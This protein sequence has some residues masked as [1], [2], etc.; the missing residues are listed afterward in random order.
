MAR[1]DSTDQSRDFRGKRVRGGEITTRGFAH[2]LGLDDAPPPHR[3]KL[4][5]WLE[6]HF[7][8][9]IGEERA[10]ML[11]ILVSP[12]NPSGP[13]F[14]EGEHI[15]VSYK[16]ESLSEAL[17]SLIKADAPGRVAE[18]TLDD[19]LQMLEEDPESDFL[20]ELKQGSPVTN[21]LTSWAGEDSYAEFFA[22]GEVVRSQLDSIDL[23]G[24]FVFI[25]HCDNECI[26]AIPHNLAPMVSAVD[27]PWEQRSR[28]LGQ[29]FQDTSLGLS[30]DDM[31]CTELTEQDV[32]VGNPDKVPDVLEHV[33][34][35]PNPDRK[36][37]FFSNTC[38]PTVTGE[39][40]ESVVRRYESKSPV[41]LVYL[42][43]TPHSMQNVFKELFVDRR[44]DREAAAGEP[45]PGAVN[46]IGFADE[47]A[48][49]DV[50]DLLRQCGVRVNS[51]LIPSLNEDLIDR[52][53]L[54]SLNVFLP[55]RIWDN[56]YDQLQTRTR[57]P[58]ISPKAPFGWEGTR[59]WLEEVL[60]AMGADA[61][62]DAI[63][64]E[65]CLQHEKAWEQ[66]KQK[67]LGHRLGFVVRAEEV[68]NLTEARFTWGVPVLEM[69]EEAGFGLD[70]LIKVDERDRARRM[71]SEI[72]GMFRVPDRHSIQGFNSFDLLRSR[73][74]ESR[75][76]AVLS[77][78]FFDW[79]LSEAGKNRFS[80]QHF[81]MGAPG[82]ARTALRLAGICALP[83]YRKY[84]KY[85]KRTET[86]LPD[87][88]PGGKAS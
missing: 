60:E 36:M 18:A 38:V 16:G 61:D 4:V 31:V 57:I 80:F 75:S 20:E 59:R 82:A 51:Q 34:S 44:L 52:L 17:E 45:D 33:L 86:G 81:E 40:V 66:A 46:L 9:F 53:P 35:D 28:Q 87:V 62:L 47:P 13:A 63:W 15:Q 22:V 77:Y 85:L 14:I 3:V 41:P 25:H 72:H 84:G 43:V 32:I 74:R 2:L 48:T 39:D 83:F 64:K 30:Q 42:T 78:H 23:G 73:L 6:D 5:V 26:Q 69:L 68:E 27:Y 24:S 11:L 79:R 67:A 50:I 37:V 88:G 55:N 29:D 65:H 10:A 54:A 21:L 56:H 70:V 7:E 71:A 8:V 58:F 49:R 19:L 76:E 12:R 1:E